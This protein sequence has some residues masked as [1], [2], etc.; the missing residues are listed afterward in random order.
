MRKETRRLGH[1]V[2][3]SVLMGL[4]PGAGQLGS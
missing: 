4:P 2:A 1:A 3:L